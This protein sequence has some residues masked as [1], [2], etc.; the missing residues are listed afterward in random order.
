M[1]R[2]CTMGSVNGFLGGT[3]EQG[4]G[5]GRDIS[6]SWLRYCTKRE[7]GV[8]RIRDGRSCMGA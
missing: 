2:P 7:H 4:V 1:S 6:E 3:F 8:V 5:T